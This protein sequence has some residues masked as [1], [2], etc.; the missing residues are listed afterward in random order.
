[1]ERVSEQATGQFEVRDYVLFQSRLGPG[2]AAYVPLRRFTLGRDA[3]DG[4]SEGIEP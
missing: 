1:M 2:G 4:S 3:A